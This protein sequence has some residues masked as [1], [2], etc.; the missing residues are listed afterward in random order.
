MNRSNRAV[1]DKCVIH[2][3][4][5]LHP[6]V[7]WSEND[8]WEYIRER[9]LP[10]P[11]LYDEGFTRIG[12]VG[13]PM[14]NKQ[15]YR[16]FKRWPGYKR[17]YLNAFQRVSDK[18]NN[19]ILAGDAHYVEYLKRYPHLKSSDDMFRWWMRDKVNKRDAQGTLF[20]N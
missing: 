10:Y 4:W 9:E 13:C 19:G 11:S 16:D 18:I 3:K 1:F 6:I 7:D 12:C 14:G 5:Y 2:H 8:V 20:D 15:R 17:A